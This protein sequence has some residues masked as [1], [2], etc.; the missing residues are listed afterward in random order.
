MLDDYRVNSSRE[1]FRLPLHK[2]I[3]AFDRFDPVPENRPPEEEMDLPWSW[4]FSSF[5][6]DGSARELTADEQMMC[7]EL[8]QFQQSGK[9]VP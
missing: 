4:L 6:D 2:V 1:F 5:P 3:E 7:R 8:E 9:E